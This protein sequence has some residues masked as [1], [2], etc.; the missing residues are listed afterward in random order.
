MSNNRTG[1]VNGINKGTLNI[2]N[3]H[4]TDKAPVKS[5]RRQ[6][7]KHKFSP[8]ADIQNV[9]VIHQIQ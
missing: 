3:Y 8:L 6:K 4:N 9:E 2:E 1:N 5:V 7:S